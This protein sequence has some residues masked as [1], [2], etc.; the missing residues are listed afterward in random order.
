MCGYN[1]GSTII[2]VFNKP[3]VCLGTNNLN[4]R[5]ADFHCVAVNVYDSLNTTTIST[6]VLN[7]LKALYF[8]GLGLV[9]HLYYFLPLLDCRMYAIAIALVKALNFG[10]APEEKFYDEKHK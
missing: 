1:L 8:K 5:A 7:Q 2:A 9:H 4:G 10:E 6:S 3:H